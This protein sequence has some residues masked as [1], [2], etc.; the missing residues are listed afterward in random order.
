MSTT[1][2]GPIWDRCPATPVVLGVVAGLLGLQ[3]G[4]TPVGP[5]VYAEVD[6]PQSPGGT[7]E[8]TLD[9]AAPDPAVHGPGPYPGLVLLHGGGWNIGHLYSDDFRDRLQEGA[10]HGYVTITVDYRLTAKSEPDLITPRWPWPAQ[11]QDVRCAVRWLRA[12]AE[13]RDVDPDAIGASGYSAGGHLAM[14][15]GIADHE[16]GFD[17]SFCTHDA[18]AAVRA[19]VSQSG[20]ADLVTMFPQT[21]AIGRYW[22]NRLLALPG[23]AT[24]DDDRAPYDDA[25]P[26]F[27]L[28]PE[29]GAA[30]LMQLQG[31][32]DTL[33][34]PEGQEDLHAAFEAAG[35]ASTL[36]LFEGGGHGWTGDADVRAREQG[37]LWLDRHLRGDDV[38]LGCSPWPS[39]AP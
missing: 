5:I 21:E 4:C 2:L 6:D 22:V 38:V 15:L 28:D 35:L 8:L 10:D 11:I 31:E 1:P 26:A 39:C 37:L 36:L 30:P 23:D 27:W 3:L 7:V 24:P 13:E 18:S 17:G 9:L 19:V 25:S 33:V 16:P 20:P 34:P 32:E 14:M 29:A 12:H